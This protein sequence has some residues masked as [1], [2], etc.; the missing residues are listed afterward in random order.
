[1]LD[2]LAIDS[3]WS[4]S[5]AGPLPVKPTL[6]ALVGSPSV[7]TGYPEADHGAARYMVL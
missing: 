5:D 6:D 7:T 1:M 2:V 4:F 3:A